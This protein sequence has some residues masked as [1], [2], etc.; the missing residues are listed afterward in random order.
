[1]VPIL[2]PQQGLNIQIYMRYISSYDSNDKNLIGMN[3]SDPF[4]QINV[5]KGHTDYCVGYRCNEDGWQVGFQVCVCPD[6][7]ANIIE[8]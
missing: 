7:K 4:F 2:K 8:F 6:E 5:Q 1:M 3:L